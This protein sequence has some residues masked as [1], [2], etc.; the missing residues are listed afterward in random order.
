MK[1]FLVLIITLFLSFAVTSFYSSAEEYKPTNTIINEGLKNFKEEL[2]AFKAN[3]YLFQQHKISVEAL[4]LSLKKTRNSYKEIEFYI[5]YHY[6]EFSKTHLNAAPL[7]HIE[8]T[9]TASNTLPP[10][11]LQVLDELVFSEEVSAQKDK[12]V[13]ITDFL[14]NS[15][16][17]FYWSAVKNGLSEEN[18]KTL[19]LRIELIRIYTMGVTGFDTPGSLNVFEEAKHAL[20][21]IDN[22]I[23][24][25]YYFK[26]FDTQKAENLLSNAIVYLS[27][28]TDFETF[29]RIEFYK[30]HLQPLYE[31]LGK[32]RKSTRLNSSHWE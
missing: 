5:A 17:D 22:Y 1:S 27:K 7:F 2:S 6:P 3:V 10:E 8:G 19:P 12:I 18:N 32:D 15:Y 21:G 9:G 23:K 11:G 16:N 20:I 29:D 4:Q 25:E 13:E 14:I 31:E 28:D 26:K 24:N 30:I